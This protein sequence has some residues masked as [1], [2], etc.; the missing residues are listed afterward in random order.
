MYLPQRDGRARMLNSCQIAGILTFRLHRVQ[1]PITFW[2]SLLI[3]ML[4]AR[5]HCQQGILVSG[6]TGGFGT[7]AQPLGAGAGAG[8]GYY[9]MRL[10]PVSLRLQGEMGIEFNDNPHYSST[11]READV[12]FQPKLNI[13]AFWP[14]TERN[15]LNLTVGLGYVEYLRDRAL[16]D[17]NITSGSTLDFNVYSGDFRFDVHERFSAINYQVQD[18]SVSAYLIRFQNTAGLAAAWNL[19]KLILV[20]GYDYNT[21]DSLS[22][23]F[24]YSDNNS[25]LFHAVGTLALSPLMKVGLQAIGGLTTY[26]ENVLDNNTHESAGA[27]YQDQFTPHL[28]ARI[29]GGLLAYQ[30]GENGTVASVG[31]QAGYYASLTVLHHLNESFSHS[32]AVGREI[33][34]GVTADLSEIYF[35]NYSAT[36]RLVWDV[37]T[38][39]TFSFNRGKTLGGVA[40]VVETYDQ[41]GPGIKVAWKINERVRA[42]ATYNFLDKESDVS[43]LSYTQNRLFLDFTYDF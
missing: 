28:T 40:G 6:D 18:P 41:Y 32:L 13:K 11:E 29:S 39:F 27:F 37:F 2:I 7:A 31:D 20:A 22:G 38:M 19:N 5:G 14:I 30:F 36:W 15:S 42:T 34:D 10:G 43:T 9:N 33:Q 12:D 21:F 26:T 3:I 1:T 16:S 4:T 25:D 35:V 24:Q 8:A 17:I 23:N